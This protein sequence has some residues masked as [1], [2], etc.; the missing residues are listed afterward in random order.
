VDRHVQADDAEIQTRV[1]ALRSSPGLVSRH[2]QCKPYTETVLSSHCCRSPVL[3]S[4]LEQT[5]LQLGQSRCTKVGMS[6][7]PEVVSRKIIHATVEMR[8]QRQHTVRMG[9][10]TCIL[11]E[12]MCPHGYSSVV[13]GEGRANL[14]KVPIVQLAQPFRSEAAALP[15]LTVL[16]METC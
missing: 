12:K 15:F 11:Q 3:L 2:V 9:W 13:L 10:L 16:L 4:L 8:T 7:P 14:S 5:M 1:L 6:G